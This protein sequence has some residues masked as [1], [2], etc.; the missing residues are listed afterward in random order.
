MKIEEKEKELIEEFEMFDDWMDKYTYIID[1]GKHSCSI[2]NIRDE[3]NLVQGCNSQV[4][5]DARFEDGKMF[6][7]ADSDALIPKGIAQMLVRIYSG[8]SPTDIVNHNPVFVKEIGLE[9]HLSPNRA[10]GLV[11]MINKMK[12]I[13]K[14]FV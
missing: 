2:N 4:W 12:N 13:S 1:M 11:S 10:N 5:L 8:N 6:F 9:E 14:S 7:R 3:K